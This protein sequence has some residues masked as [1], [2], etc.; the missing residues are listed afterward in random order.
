MQVLKKKLD[1]SIIIIMCFVCPH[2]SNYGI[3]IHISFVEYE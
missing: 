1:Y 3:A 2:E